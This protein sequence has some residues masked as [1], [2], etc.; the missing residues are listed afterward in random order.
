[1]QTPVLSKQ[2]GKPYSEQTPPTDDVMESV[3]RDNR[4]VT[5]CKGHSSYQ[6]ISEVLDRLKPLNPLLGEGGFGRVYKVVCGVPHHQQQS[7]A[8]KED[9]TPEKPCFL[10]NEMKLLS[11][12]RHPNIVAFYGGARIEEPQSTRILMVME[13]CDI[14]LHEKI[15]RCARKGLRL[16]GM[17]TRMGYLKGVCS[18]LEFLFR[19]TGHCH[20]DV[21]SANVMIHK[22][23]TAKIIDLGL[24]RDEHTIKSR[25]IGIVCQH[26]APEYH[27]QSPHKVTSSVDIWG[28]GNIACDLVTGHILPKW[29]QQVVAMAPPTAGTKQSKKTIQKSITDVRQSP[30]SPDPKFKNK[31]MRSAAVCMEKLVRPCLRL[32]PDKRPQNIP[33]IITLI[34]EVIDQSET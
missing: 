27:Y 23:G 31:D 4:R 13:H 28:I 14:S 22:D 5:W 30:A 16:F 2:V 20:S 6:E 19:K 3:T 34:D 9:L 12:A 32:N 33:A 11:R 18:G 21:K 17:R 8:V 24:A 25:K 15:L 10:I 29:Q 7:F 26:M 1:M